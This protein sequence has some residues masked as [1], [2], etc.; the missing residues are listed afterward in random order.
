M[1]TWKIEVTLKVADNWVEDGFDASERLQQI[2]QS[3][4]DLLPY[5]Y[6]EEVVVKAKVT[7]APERKVIRE[8]QGYTY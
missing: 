3:F 2:E 4:A 6:D 1:K 8:L 5:A 7:S